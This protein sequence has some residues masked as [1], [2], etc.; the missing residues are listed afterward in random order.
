MGRTGEE[1]RKD[2][3]KEEGRK[4]RGSRREDISAE[5]QSRVGRESV[6]ARGG[7]SG[8]QSQTGRTHAE[9]GEVAQTGNESRRAVTC[10]GAATGFLVL[11]RPLLSPSLHFPLRLP[12]STDAKLDGEPLAGGVRV[13][14][15][16]FPASASRPSFHARANGTTRLCAAALSRTFSVLRRPP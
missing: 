4:N 14:Q 5:S 12:L 6:V 15:L 2:Q 11:H 9:R 8:S 10:A 13:Q 16:L 1:Q 3:R 7:R